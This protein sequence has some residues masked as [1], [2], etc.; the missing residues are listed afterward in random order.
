MS[1]NTRRTGRWIA[2]HIMIF[3][4]WQIFAELQLIAGIGKKRY[5]S[6]SMTVPT[7][8]GD[9][10][11]WGCSHSANPAMALN[12]DHLLMH[13]TS[14]SWM[15]KRAEF[16]QVY[17][18]VEAQRQR[19]ADIRIQIMSPVQIPYLVDTSAVYLKPAFRAKI[20]RSEVEARKQEILENAGRCW[21]PFHMPAFPQ[22]S[23]FTDEVKQRRLGMAIQQQGDNDY[24]SD[25][26]SSDEESGGEGKNEMRRKRNA[27]IKSQ[28]A[29]RCRECLQGWKGIA[30]HP[31]LYLCLWDFYICACIRVHVSMCTYI[32]H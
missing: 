10:F 31:H 25:G 16:F 28:T 24:I 29:C 32:F 6:S 11:W 20:I 19:I 13:L 21:H 23:V 3:W 7:Y 5:G 9:I 14:L 17:E 22:A 18:S 12:T 15:L 4:T 8:L 26:D 1:Q 2:I 27:L 30:P